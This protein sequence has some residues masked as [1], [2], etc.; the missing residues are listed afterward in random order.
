LR[1]RGSGDPLAKARRQADALDDVHETVRAQ[2]AAVGLPAQ[3]RTE[4]GQAAVVGADQWLVEQPERLV[5]ERLDQAAG[6]IV[7]TGW[8]G[9]AG[10]VVADR[11]EAFFLD[12]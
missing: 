1:D 10:G 2:Q 3:Q 9:G 8:P 11:V 7:A 12:P 4:A 5:V 6:E